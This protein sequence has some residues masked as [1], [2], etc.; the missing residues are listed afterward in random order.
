MALAL[1]GIL[2]LAALVSFPLLNYREANA[3]NRSDASKIINVPKGQEQEQ[4]QDKS[5][6]NNGVISAE[7]GHGQRRT[8]SKEW[9]INLWMQRRYFWEGRDCYFW[10]C[11]WWPR[12]KW[13]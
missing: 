10:L 2:V 4:A 1:F 5:T 13:G 3:L 9:N 7:Y 12:A 8:F 6:D 11:K